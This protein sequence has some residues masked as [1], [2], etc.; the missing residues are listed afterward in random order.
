MQSIPAT[1]IDMLKVVSKEDEGYRRLLG[2]IKQA[3]NYVPSIERDTE[4]DILA[5]LQSAVKV[6][7]VPFLQE[8][9]EAALKIIQVYE[10]RRISPLK[11]AR[12]FHQEAPAVEQKVKDLQER[13]SYL[14]VGIVDYV[15]PKDQGGSKEAV[16]KTAEGIEDD[17]KELLRCGL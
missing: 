10:I 12:Q 8:A 16:V 7:P 11:V 6:I 2:A 5:V 17:I 9:I 15:T 3:Y 14:M 4:K 1:H 13:V